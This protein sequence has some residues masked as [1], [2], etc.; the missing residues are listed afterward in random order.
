M[1]IYNNEKPLIVL[2]N[3]H[4]YFKQSYKVENINLLKY[5]NTAL[6]VGNKNYETNLDDWYKFIYSSASTHIGSMSLYKIIW[7]LKD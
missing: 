2:G 1:G 7:V 5:L 3:P 6:H 4:A